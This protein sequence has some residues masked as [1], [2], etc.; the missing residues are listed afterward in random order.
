MKLVKNETTKKTQKEENVKRKEHLLI[1]KK[2]NQAH[3]RKRIGE[4]V[5]N[6][7]TRKG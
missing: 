4:R 5:Q 1:N 7:N 3:K 6:I 2:K